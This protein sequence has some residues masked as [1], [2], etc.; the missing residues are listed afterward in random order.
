MFIT[1]RLLKTSIFHCL[2]PTRLFQLFYKKLVNCFFLISSGL[3]RSKV[4]LQLWFSYASTMVSG[5]IP[6]IYHAYMTLIPRIYN[7]FI[8]MRGICVNNT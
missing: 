5:Y 2:P 7:A 3:S 8:L 1:I 4:V 6:R